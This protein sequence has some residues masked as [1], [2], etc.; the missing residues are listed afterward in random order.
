MLGRL[1]PWC[2]ITLLWAGALSAQQYDLRTYSLEH[3]MPGA[4]VNA[5]CE[6]SAGYLWIGTN[7]GIS[8]TDG[9]HFLTIGRS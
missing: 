2:L 3:G 6:D 5:F 9:L 7:E 1:A 8:R 4:A